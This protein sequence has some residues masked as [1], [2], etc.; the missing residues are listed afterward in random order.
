MLS[1]GKRKRKVDIDGG[2]PLEIDEWYY[3]KGGGVT[4]SKYYTIWFLKVGYL[5][6]P[7]QKVMKSNARKMSC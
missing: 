6:K 7:E 4:I 1:R 5:G 2:L 3:T